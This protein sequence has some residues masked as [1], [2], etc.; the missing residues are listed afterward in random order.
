MQLKIV[1]CDAVET[2]CEFM[3]LKIMFRI[4]FWINNTKVL[5]SIGKIKH[6]FTLSFDINIDIL[7]LQN[8]Y[9]SFVVLYWFQIISFFVTAFFSHMWYVYMDVHAHLR[10]FMLFWYSFVCVFLVLKNCTE[11]NW[12]R[13]FKIRFSPFSIKER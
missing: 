5:L 12:S 4:I 2:I 13:S 8:W 9:R 1:I 3:K 6:Y 10:V 7:G 11:Y